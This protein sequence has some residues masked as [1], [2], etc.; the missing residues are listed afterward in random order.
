MQQQLAPKKIRVLVANRS[1]LL[2]DVITM[3]ISGQPDIEVIGEIGGDAA[4]EPAVARTCPDFVIITFDK[5]DRRPALCDQL[6]A[7]YPHLKVLTIAAAANRSAFFWTT[8]EVRSATFESSEQS[9]LEVLR[10]GTPATSPVQ[11]H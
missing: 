1:R 8:L 6:L 11:V 7:R 10:R 5:P 3:S 2:Q 4:I 9:L